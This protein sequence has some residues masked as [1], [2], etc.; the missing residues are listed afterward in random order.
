MSDQ[1]PPPTPFDPNATPPPPAYTP[2]PPP[3]VGAPV[4][5][6]GQYP[7]QYAT[8]AGGYGPIGNVRGTGVSILLAIVTFGIYPIVWYYKVHEEMK[9]HTGTGLGGLVAFLLAFFVGVAS[10]FLCSAE[11]GELYARQGR[12]KPVSGI[13]GLWYIPGFLLFLIGP[14]VWFVKTNGALNEYWKS[15][16]A[17]G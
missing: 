13:T 16:G 8:G 14:I 7:P 15:M 6:P 12:E 11:V 10:P 17:Q 9:Q 4:A 5:P 2:P 3:P 1:F